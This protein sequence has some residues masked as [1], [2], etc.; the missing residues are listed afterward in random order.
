[1]SRLLSIVEFPSGHPP[2]PIVEGRKED[3]WSE[4]QKGGFS[5]IDGGLESTMGKEVP[6]TYT[7]SSTQQVR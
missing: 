6:P 7:S 5:S 4:G 3:L 1:M 2:P